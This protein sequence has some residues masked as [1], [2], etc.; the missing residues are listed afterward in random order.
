MPKTF[1]S[2]DA[3]IEDCWRLA[4]IVFTSG[5]KADVMIALWRGGAP[6][7]VAMH[8]YFKVAGWDVRHTAIKCTSYTAIGENAGEVS[9]EYADEVLSSLKKGEKV[10]IVDDVFDTGKT[11]LAVKTRLSEMGVDFRIATVYYKP[12]KNLTDIKPDYFV[13]D[14]SEAWIVFPHEIE[15]LTREEILFKNPV[16][17]GLINAH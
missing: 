5:W 2:A 1:L 17:A 11:A 14:V 9:F 10:L 3:Y 15:G 8:E 6:V 16:L 4:D 13:K 12:E 7:G